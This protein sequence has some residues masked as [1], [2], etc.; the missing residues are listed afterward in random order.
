MRVPLALGAW[1]L[2]IALAWMAALPPEGGV[3]PLVDA[4]G[5]ASGAWMLRQHALYLSGLWSI[6]LMSL[7]MVLAL[8]LPLL[9]RPLGGM[10][11]VYRLH[12]WAGIGAGITAI[13]HWA[14]KESS[15]WI[16]DLWGSAGRPARDALVPWL[17]DG[18]HLAKDLGEWAF[19]LLL[20]MLLFTLWQRLLPYRRWRIVHRAMPVLYLLL[21]F[22]AAVLTPLA[23]WVQP[24]GLL[25]GALLALGSLAA[26]WSLA[27]R[28]GRGRSHAAR[29]HAVRA[30]GED[31]AAPLEVICAMPPT[32]PGHRAGQFVFARFDRAEGAHPFTIASAPGA[33]GHSADGEP[34]L[35]LV[36]KPLGDYTRSLHQR[37]RAG[38]GVRIEGPYG[39]FDGRARAGR[40][41]LWVAGGVGVTPFL[42]LLEAR[43]PGA[44]AQGAPVQ[45]HYC[46]RD[47][48]NDALLP[49][50]RA[51][52]ERAQPPVRLT[53]HGEAQG[54]RL[55]PQDLRPAT[56]GPVDLWFCGPRGLGQ[57]LR[58]HTRRMGRWRLRQE[59][60]A[61]R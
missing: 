58:R 44:A 22:H 50:L 8:R 43:Q 24:L 12:K 56:A 9:E 60:F 21:A 4:Q 23:F 18:R 33:L 19:Y 53:V 27:G 48:R 49:R 52:C 31:G 15:G 54:Q 10:D 40:E 13:A 2:G 41:Q 1:L 39:H 38:Q 61:M 17:A 32:W 30:L 36:I 51:L 11:Q 57:A 35:R 3:W 26:L 16:K 47:A 34:L 29:V 37:L 45:M 6:G 5:A 28:I 46:T 25:L 14:A 59:S 7:V 20:G 42:A 55:A